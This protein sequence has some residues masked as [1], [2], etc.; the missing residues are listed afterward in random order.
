MEK[1]EH[2][3]ELLAA[4]ALDILDEAETLQVNLHLAE[5]DTC[6]AELQD[7]QQVSEQLSLAVGEVQPDGRVK[8]RLLAE[9]DP[10]VVERDSPKVR[11]WRGRF[12]NLAGSALRTWSLVSL[13]LVAA[14][15]VSNILLWRQINQPEIP[16]TLR[17]VHLVGGETSPQ[18]RGMLVVS[19]DG[20]HGT[21]VVDGLA[22]LEAEFEYQLWLMREGEVSSGGT[23]RVYQDGYGHMGVASEQPLVHYERFLVTVESEGGW[24]FPSGPLVLVGEME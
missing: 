7:Y 16:D 10:G 1:R 3:S 21:L 13:L 15:V 17:V 11:A 9:V 8:A 20:E 23:F 5:C 22:K 12:A 6:R 19:V 18:A 2:V 24:H 4:F 14:L